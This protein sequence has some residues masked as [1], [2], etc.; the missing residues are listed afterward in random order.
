MKVSISTVCVRV[1]PIVCIAVIDDFDFVARSLQFLFLLRFISIWFEWTLIKLLL[2]LERRNSFH[3]FYVLYSHD[4]NRTSP[5]SIPAT[6]STPKLTSL[7][8]Y[9]T[10]NEIKINQSFLS[11]CHFHYYNTICDVAN[12][13][14]NTPARSFFFCVRIPIDFFVVW[15]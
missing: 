12:E 10:V 7:I 15:F 11:H 6:Y 9:C 2:S 8:Y 13:P 5:T 1:R 14:G 4:P 3:Q